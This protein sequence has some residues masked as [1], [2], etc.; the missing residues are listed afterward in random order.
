M[1][2]ASPFSAERGGATW[3]FQMTFGFLVNNN[4]MHKL[5]IRSIEEVI[6]F[7]IMTHLVGLQEGHQHVKACIG[8]LAIQDV[9]DSSA[10]CFGLAKHYQFGHFFIN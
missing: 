1:E 3:L 7:S 4:V 2:R 5:N 8:N 6:S 10:D 9:V